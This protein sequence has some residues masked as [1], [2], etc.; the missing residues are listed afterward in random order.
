MYACHSF[1]IRS[2][3]DGHL[4]CFHVLAIVNSTAMN[5]GVYVFFFYVSFSIL[6]SSGYMPSSGMEETH[7]YL[8]SI[9]IDIWQKPLQYCKVIIL[10]LNEYLKKFF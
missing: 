6:V 5:I 10:Q 4:V 3:A 9:H 8:W 2:P 7:L 1:L